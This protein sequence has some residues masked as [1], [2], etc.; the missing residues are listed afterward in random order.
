MMA[1]ME[2]E[3]NYSRMKLLLR[4]FSMTRQNKLQFINN[5]QSYLM[6]EVLE[7]RWKHLVENMKD[8]KSLDEV[9]A[10]HN[11]YLDKILVKSLLD[12]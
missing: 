6:F 1:S 7:S 3:N 11:D 8:T 5:L 4:K 2:H 9:V 10:S 12:E